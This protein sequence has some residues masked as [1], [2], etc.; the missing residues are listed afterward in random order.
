MRIITPTLTL[1]SDFATMLQQMLEKYEIFDV[2]TQID[3]FNFLTGKTC[4]Y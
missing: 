2:I 1:I 3:R 4:C